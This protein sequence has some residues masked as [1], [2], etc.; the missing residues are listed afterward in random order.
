MQETRDSFRFRVIPATVSWVFGTVVLIGIPFMAYRVWNRFPIKYPESLPF[1]LSCYLSVA[2]V[3]CFL[4]IGLLLIY[5]GKE[6]MRGKWLLA[7]IP[8]AIAATILGILETYR[9][10]ISDMY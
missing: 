1:R 5:S 10:I 7:L 8:Y 2:A 4:L 6:W 9:E 3:P